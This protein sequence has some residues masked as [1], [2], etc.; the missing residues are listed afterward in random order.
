ML[1]KCYNVT[2]GI[3]RAGEAMTDI[4]QKRAARRKKLGTD[5]VEL[6][7][8]KDSETAIINGNEHIPQPV[9]YETGDTHSGWTL[10]DKGWEY[11]ISK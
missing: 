7:V 5:Q 11:G 9:L 3:K 6:T 1:S 2:Y 4:E 8:Q 10:T